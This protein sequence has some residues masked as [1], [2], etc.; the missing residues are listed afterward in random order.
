MAQRRD[1]MHP[2]LLVTQ[3]VILTGSSTAAMTSPMLIAS[4]LRPSTYP[5][6][7]PRIERTRPLRLQLH[8]KLLEIGERKLQA[9]RDVAKRNG[10]RIALPCDF[11]NRHDGVTP[12]GAEQHFL[13]LRAEFARRP[14]KFT[15]VL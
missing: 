5:P 14:W 1:A 9:A 7:G 3:R 11:D 12:F 8:E 6:P 2:S 10:L 13:L 15:P 4:A